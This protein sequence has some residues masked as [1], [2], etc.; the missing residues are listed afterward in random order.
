M[1]AL[2]AGRDVQRPS[3]EGRAQLRQAPAQASAQQTPSTQKL[4]AHSAAAA[5]TWPFC[6]GP[7]LPFTQARPA[8]QSALL[9]HLLLQ[10]PPTQ[11]NGGQ[12]WTP[13]GRHV[14]WPSQVPGVLR[15]SPE[16]DAW[17]QM[18]S[19][20]YFSQPPNPSQDPVW[21]QLAAPPSLQTLRGS[22]FPGSMGQQV[23]SCP[24]RLQDTHAP[25]HA[26]EQQT[27]SVQ[28]PDTQSVLVPQAAPFGLLP[29]LPLT[30]WRPVTQSLFLVQA[31]KQ[32]FLAASHENG[33]QILVAPGRQRPLPSQTLMP[34]TASPS[35]VPV[36]QV[37]PSRCLRQPP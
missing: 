11:R 30:H 26:T 10:A 31:E 14:P 24:T 33:A 32:S 29:Q 3:D 9:V 37:V 17:M 28:N 8:A 13:G 23:P 7:Q 12:S 4:D 15:R 16:H 18:L 22:G 35:H 25:W 6:L 34:A 1:S 19:A 2:L 27:P 20:A 5:H 36:W 21:P